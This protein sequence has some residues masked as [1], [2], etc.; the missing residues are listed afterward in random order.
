VG[1]SDRIGFGHPRLPLV[2]CWR[3]AL[4]HSD[5][6]ELDAWPNE[7]GVRSTAIRHCDASPLRRATGKT[8]SGTGF[9]TFDG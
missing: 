8:L 6:P 7:A 4:R 2:P 3:T 1:L 9:R 5:F